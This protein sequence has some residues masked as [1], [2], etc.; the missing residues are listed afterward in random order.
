MV[1]V[2]SMLVRSNEVPWRAR[3]DGC[4][5]G[6]P[7]TKIFVSTGHHADLAAGRSKMLV[8]KGKDRDFRTVQNTPKAKAVNNE[9]GL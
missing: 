4:R 3:T 8:Q 6:Y 5:G 9:V 7:E 1:F 2:E